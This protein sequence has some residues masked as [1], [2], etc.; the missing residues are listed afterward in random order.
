M[1]NP[2]GCESHANKLTVK[3][4][5]KASGVTAETI[6]HYSQIGLLNPRRDPDNSYRYFSRRDIQTVRFVKQAKLLGYT[7]ADIMLLIEFS[8]SGQSPC[9]RAKE[10]LQ[11][12][13]PKNRKRLEVMLDGQTKLEQAL[14]QWSQLPDG[15]PDGN[16]IRE[17]IENI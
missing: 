7:L 1:T 15:V 10:I 13:A 4:I 6:R 9:P 3:T 2:V 5:A 8:D 11:G 16:N 12:R 14:L 17:L